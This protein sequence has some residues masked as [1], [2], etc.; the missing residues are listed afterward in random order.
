MPWLSTKG[1]CCHKNQTKGPLE[2]H[3]NTLPDFAA[4]KNYVFTMD[5]YMYVPLVFFADGWDVW[6]GD[7]AEWETSQRHCHQSQE[8]RVNDGSSTESWHR[9]QSLQYKYYHTAKNFHPTQLKLHWKIF[10][11]NVDRKG[12]HRLYVIINTGTKS[13]AHESRGRKRWKFSPG[14]NFQLYGSL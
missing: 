1:C 5:M 11:A 4:K 8:S 2:Q 6:W 9:G 10:F 12:C 7:G 3:C 14:E 13:F